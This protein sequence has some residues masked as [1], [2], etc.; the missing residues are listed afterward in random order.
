LF[1]SKDSEVVLESGS[2]SQKRRDE[3]DKIDELEMSQICWDTDPFAELSTDDSEPEASVDVRSQDTDPKPGHSRMLHQDKLDDKNSLEMTQ[4]YWGADPFIQ[5]SD[6][7]DVETCPS[8]G[9]KKE[10][11]G[12]QHHQVSSDES[13]VAPTPEKKRHSKVRLSMKRQQDELDKQDSLEMTQICWDDEPFSDNLEKVVA[14]DEHKVDIK[15]DTSSESEN[16]QLW[17]GEKSFW[18]NLNLDEFEEK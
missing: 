15:V 7:S 13:M 17:E 5:S 3:Q 1:Q 12:V 11:S 4:A 16:S 6:S 8:S 18:K 10:D 2:L 9:A 14:D